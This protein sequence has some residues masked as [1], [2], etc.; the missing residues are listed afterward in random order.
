VSGSQN[1]PDVLHQNGPDVLHQNGPD[2][3]YQN[4]NPG[5]AQ[6]KYDLAFVPTNWY[7][8]VNDCCFEIL[9]CKQADCLL[10]SAF[11]G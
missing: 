4:A 7:H 11:V 2:V 5:A 6:C 3:L 10:C 1:A 9:L 8:V